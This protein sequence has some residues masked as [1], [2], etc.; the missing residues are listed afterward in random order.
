MKLQIFKNRDLEEELKYRKMRKVLLEFIWDRYWQINSPSFVPPF[1]MMEDD[2]V[3]LE[4][5][6]ILGFK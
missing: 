4:L 3:K 6:R 1:P 2:Q 5:K